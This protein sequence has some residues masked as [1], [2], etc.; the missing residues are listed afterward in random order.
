LSATSTLQWR[1]G[2][3]DT[4]PNGLIVNIEAG[5]I[6]R[7]GGVAKAE[8]DTV[9]AIVDCRLECGHATRRTYQF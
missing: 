4:L 2:V 1:A 6:T 3:D 5:K 7:I 9:S 8:V